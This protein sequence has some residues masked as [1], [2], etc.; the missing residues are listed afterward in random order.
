[1]THEFPIRVYYED[2]DMAG[3]V[4]YANYLKFFERARSEAV[5]QAGIDQ[6]ALRDERGL[7]FV[8]RRAE[9]DYLAPARFDDIIVI[10][11]RVTRLGAATLLMAQDAV[12]DG[13]VLSQ[14]VIKI[15]LM[16]LSGRVQRFEQDIRDM[17]ATLGGTMT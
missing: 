1:M 9:I 6:R 13:H 8:V 14:A 4:Y 15:A 10:R 3:I 2:T 11:S 5:R 12:L 17:L 7:V 16:T